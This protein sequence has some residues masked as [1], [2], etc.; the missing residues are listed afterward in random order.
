VELVEP[1]KPFTLTGDAQGGLIKS[2]TLLDMHAVAPPST[3]ISKE[4]ESNIALE[5]LEVLEEFA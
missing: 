3:K 4:S 5:H 2:E 1:L